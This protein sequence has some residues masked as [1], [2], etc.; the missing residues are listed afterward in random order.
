M[1]TGQSPLGGERIDRQPL[2]IT[3]ANSNFQFASEAQVQIRPRAREE[4]RPAGAQES[5]PWRKPWVDKQRSESPSGAKEKLA[6]RHSRATH[7]SPSYEKRGST[8]KLPGGAT[9]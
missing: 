2:P 1:G 6:I 3:C 8:W 4:R 5:I 9:S 7:H